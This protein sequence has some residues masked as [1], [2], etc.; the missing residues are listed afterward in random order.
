[1]SDGKLL[2]ARELLQFLGHMSE[3]D[4]SLLKL[5]MEFYKSD[6]VP[7]L[8]KDPGELPAPPADAP[9]RQR[10]EEA[11]NSST[12]GD[13]ES[14]LSHLSAL[15][16]EVPNSPVVWKA[17]ARAR[18]AL[19]DNDG[20]IAAL[21][22]DVAVDSSLEDTVESEARA[23]LLAE[24]PLGDQID[25]MQVTW[26]VKDAERLNEALLSAP[27][28]R[29]IPFNPADLAAEDS[30]PPKAIFMLLDRQPAESA[31]GLTFESVPR[32]LGQLMLFGKQTDR[33]ARLELIGLL[34]TELPAVKALLTGLGGEW[35][36]TLSEEK[37]IGR[38]SASEDSLKPQWRP[39][40]GLSIAQLQ[41]F[42][43][44]FHRQA[45]LQRWPN[46]KLGCLDGKTP[47][48]ALAE[49]VYK[50]RVLA[51]IMVL[52]D[53]AESMRCKFDFNELRRQAGLAGPRPDRSGK[54]RRV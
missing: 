35:L 4:Q 27:Q 16:K 24:N 23:M 8:L 15:S 19:G 30:P 20:C 9:W 14:A 1:M 31:E 29:S 3:K 5:I 34:T 22:K 50:V 10:Y 38:T 33:E 42:V 13:W 41:E 43:A 36:G 54:D 48:E 32:F 17:L 6:S 2:A 37:S 39:P 18:G 47:R 49:G 12:V 44:A 40:T 21:R 51:A 26:T 46:M 28:L 11:L 7:L 52:Q 25:V 53:V 45:L